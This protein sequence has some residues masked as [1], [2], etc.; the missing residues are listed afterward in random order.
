MH[1]RAMYP[2]FLQVVAVFTLIYTAG[3]TSYGQTGGALPSKKSVSY[4]KCD[5]DAIVIASDVSGNNRAV[6]GKAPLTSLMDL[7][8]SEIDESFSQPRASTSDLYDTAILYSAVQLQNSDVNFH[9]ISEFYGLR[10]KKIDLSD[11][12]VTNGQLRDANNGYLKA[13]GINART[14]EKELDAIELQVLRDVVSSGGSNLLVYETPSDASQNRYENI[15]VLTDNKILGTSKLTDS[16]KDWVISVH[17]PWITREFTGLKLS[18]LEPQDDLAI[19]MDP[20]AADVNAIISATDD[21][22]ALYPVFVRW[23]LGK[24]NVFLLGSRQMMNLNEVGIRELYQTRHFSEIVPVM[25]FLRYAGGRE[26]WHRD[27]DYVNLTIDDPPWKEP[28]GN[29]SFKK[30]LNEME[31]HNFHTTIAF[32]PWNYDRSESEVVNL[33]LNYPERYSL[34]I[35]GNNHDHYEFQKYKKVPI[36]EQEKD[37]IEALNRME[38][39]RRLTRIP[40][41]NVMIFPHG[42]SPAGTLELLKKYNFRATVNNEIISLGESAREDQSSKMELAEMDYGGVAVIKRH[43]VQG[44]EI[45]SF[46]SA[47]THVRVA[48]YA[49]DLFLDQ[50]VLLGTHQDYFA[51]GMDAFNPIADGI[52]ELV[53]EVEWKSLGHIIEHLYL[54]K[55]NDDGS[56]DC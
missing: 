38:E 10:Y 40:F 32:I 50:P 4:W 15:K 41:G 2:H 48:P 6:D 53:G 14:V 30:L 9:K 51:S 45:W 43:P 16:E 34:V 3:V 24:G 47:P 33:F 19:R 25:M 8:T 1:E 37:I 49:F 52:N 29:L 39:H 42:I 5:A 44:Y 46:D 36:H 11:V 7:N 35:H 54:E 55:E 12:K 31:D 56:V 26:A 20:E 18:Y 17:Y 13:I 27:I 23:K 22:S 28:Y 21:S